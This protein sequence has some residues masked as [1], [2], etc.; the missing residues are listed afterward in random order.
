[1]GTVKLQRM[2]ALIQNELNE[3]SKRK[4]FVQFKVRHGLDYIFMKSDGTAVLYESPC[5]LDRGL[6][7]DAWYWLDGDV[8]F[9]AEMNAFRVVRLFVIEQDN[10]TP[11]TSSTTVV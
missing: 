1:M 10:I 7:V 4:I 3:R 9:D 5:E 8:H 6:I 11:F 2:L